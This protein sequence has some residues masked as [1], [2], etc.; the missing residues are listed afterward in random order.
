VKGWLSEYS[1]ADA[2]Q[3]LQATLALL[4]AIFLEWLAQLRKCVKEDGDCIE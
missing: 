3:L 2:D 1:P 4:N